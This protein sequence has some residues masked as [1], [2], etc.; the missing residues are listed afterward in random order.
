MLMIT[1]TIIK[2]R[3]F[4][5][6]F[7]QISMIVDLPLLGLEKTMSHIDSKDFTRLAISS[8]FYPRAF[9]REA[10]SQRTPNGDSPKLFKQT[11]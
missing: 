2:K 3:Y 9:L 5:I 10:L 6:L 8:S 4:S 11:G 7:T 1:D